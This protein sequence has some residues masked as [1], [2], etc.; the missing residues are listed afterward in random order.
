MV[1]AAQLFTVQVSRTPEATPSRSLA[2]FP[3]R[4]PSCDCCHRKGLGVEGPCWRA[5]AGVFVSA[6]VGLLSRSP[7]CQET[8]AR[9]G[10][11]GTQGRG[12]RGGRNGLCVGAAGGC[13]LSLET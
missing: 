2:K 12:S 13:P 4:A 5:Q 7:S 6:R 11:R 3:P 9:A 8:R 10:A 1:G